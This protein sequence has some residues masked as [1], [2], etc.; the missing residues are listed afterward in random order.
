MN[1]ILTTHS[2]NC[3]INNFIRCTF[4]IFENIVFYINVYAIASYSKESIL[5][6]FVLC[7]I[8]LV[9]QMN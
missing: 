8:L 2:N 1:A 6:V 3:M 4:C 7:G 9:N 5:R